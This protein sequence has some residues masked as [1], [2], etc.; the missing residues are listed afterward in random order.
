MSV[1][2]LP[3]PGEFSFDLALT[4]LKRS[5][6]ELLHTLDGDKVFKA[7][8]INNVEVLIS[9]HQDE[10]DLLI[11]FLNAKPNAAIKAGAVEYIREWFDLDT[12]LKPFY[13]MAK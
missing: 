9:I 5:P 2:R 13:A 8:H 4:F 3:M 7:L 10:N 12:N 1:V 6:R 11:K